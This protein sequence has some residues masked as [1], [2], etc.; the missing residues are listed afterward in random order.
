MTI[1]ASA[2]LCSAPVSFAPTAADS[3]SNPTTVSTD[4]ASGSS[5]PVGTTIVK[6]T[7]VDAAGNQAVCTTTVTVID[8]EAPAIAG[9]SIRRARLFP[10]VKEMV[11]YTVNYAATDAC[12]TAN[13]SLAVTFVDVRKR[14]GYDDHDRDRRHD[15]GRDEHDGRD[16]GHDR[17]H[18]PDFVIVD[19]HHVWLRVAD[20]DDWLRTYTI[21]VTASDAAGNRSTSS[22]N[23]RAPYDDD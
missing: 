3:C 16:K 11:D 5:F 18:G 19:N 9:L 13:A 17:K 1:N 14:H 8:N 22:V 7:A 23:V 21:T 4:V 6:G 12:G 10:R 20:D 2:G 15:N